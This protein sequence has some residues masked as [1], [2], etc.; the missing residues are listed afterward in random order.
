[1][2]DEWYAHFVVN[3]RQYGKIGA[4]HPFTGIVRNAVPGLSFILDNF[5]VSDLYFDGFARGD[6]ASARLQ[7][8]VRWPT[9]NGY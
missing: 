3:Y 5:A 8:G 4:Q 1:L 2:R 7:S 9:A 6:I